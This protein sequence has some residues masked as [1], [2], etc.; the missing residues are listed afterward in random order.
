M[1]TGELESKKVP[2]PAADRLLALLKTGGP[3][4]AAELGAAL[5]V[6]GEAARQQLV[7]LAADGLVEARSETHG[8]GR[9][10]RSPRAHGRGRP[11]WRVPDPSEGGKRRS[12][13]GASPG[14]DGRGNLGAAYGRSPVRGVGLSTLLTAFAAQPATKRLTA[15]RTTRYA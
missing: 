13:V 14:R 3:R 11:P 9:R 12:P 6:T 1:S 15:V 2:R 7:K 10:G 8:V 4:T 5:G